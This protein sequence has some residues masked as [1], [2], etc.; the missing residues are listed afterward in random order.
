[1]DEDAFRER[2]A[3]KA[4]AGAD[5]AFQVVPIDASLLLKQQA[6]RQQ[7]RS[8]P[9]RDP[10][11]QVAVDYDYKVSAHDVLSVIVWDHPELT[12]PAGEFRS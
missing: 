3:G 11:A 10:L 12:I 9:L 4:D 6:A 7:V 8:A 2:Y 1:M 5:D